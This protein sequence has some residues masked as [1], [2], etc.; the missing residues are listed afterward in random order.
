[1]ERKTKIGKP[2]ETINFSPY[3][4]EKTTTPMTSMPISDHPYLSLTAPPL[5][6]WDKPDR[7]HFNLETIMQGADRHNRPRRPM[8]AKELRINRIDAIP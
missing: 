7:F 3:Y 2:K 6:M 5:S 1:M 4:P 8:G